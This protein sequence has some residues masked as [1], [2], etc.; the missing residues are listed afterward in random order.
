[1]K[2]AL[3]ALI[4]DAAYDNNNANDNDTNDTEDNNDANDN[5]NTDENNDDVLGVVVCIVV[6]IGVVKVLCF[7]STG[8]YWSC[9]EGGPCKTE[10]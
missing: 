1:V 2:L 9:L 3:E 10:G 8:L 6:I 7:G 4:D 5:N